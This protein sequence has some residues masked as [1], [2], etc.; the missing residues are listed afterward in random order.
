MVDAPSLLHTHGIARLNVH[1]GSILRPK[2]DMEAAFSDI[3]WT[4]RQ[5][6][7]TENGNGG[8]ILRHKMDLRKVS[9]CPSVQV[10]AIL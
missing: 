4:W 8:S 1:G 10:T 3:K 2:M 6:S 9:L 7:Q 5:Y